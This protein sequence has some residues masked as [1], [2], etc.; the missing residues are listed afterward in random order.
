[1]KTLKYSLIASIVVLAYFG[2]MTFFSHKYVDFTGLRFIIELFTIP[3]LLVLPVSLFFSLRYFRRSPALAVANCIV[4]AA[5]IG[6]F[7]YIG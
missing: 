5:I 7:F 3:L 6:F 4:I 2:I 1:M